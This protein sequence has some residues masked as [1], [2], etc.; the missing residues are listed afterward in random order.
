MTAPRTSESA[1][2]ALAARDV[3][4]LMV[5]AVK[6]AVGP[7]LADLAAAANAPAAVSV[8]PAEAARLLSMPPGLI[9]ELDAAGRFP[10]PA[11]VIGERRFWMVADLRAW[12]GSGCPD[13]ATFARLRDAA[14]FGD[15]PGGT[16]P[17]R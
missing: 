16:G 11:A 9:E 1:S 8:G 10:A 12:I 15:T 2:G 14:V 7:L 4:D 5:N 3:H 6:V 13:R 17:T